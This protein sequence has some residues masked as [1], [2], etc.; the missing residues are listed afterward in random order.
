MRVAV[1]LLAVVALAGCSGD[2]DADTEPTAPPGS[3]V[4]TSPGLG[5]PFCDRVAE[6]TAALDADEPPDD[7]EAF[8]IEAYQDL[9]ALAPAD[10]VPD[11][12]AM[13]AA[14]RGSEV[15]TTVATSVP[16][17]APADNSVPPVVV[18]TPGERIADYIATNCGRIDANPGPQ[19][20]VPTGGYDTL[21]DTVPPTSGA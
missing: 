10:L 9:A 4:V 21:P 18:V 17:T 5:S 1:A 7:V 2:D 3:A 15:T 19:A 14:L 13:V 6:M 8:L 12:E 11:L 20:T 16:A